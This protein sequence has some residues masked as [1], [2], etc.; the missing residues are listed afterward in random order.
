MESYLRVNLLGQGPLLIKKEL[1]DRGLT[2]VKK[3]WSIALRLQIRGYTPP[4]P[5]GVSICCLIKRIPFSSHF[6]LWPFTVSSADCRSIQDGSRNR[7]YVTRHLSPRV[8]LSARHATKNTI[9]GGNIIKR[10][11]VANSA[12]FT[13]GSALL[14]SQNSLT[15]SGKRTGSVA[16][17][18]TSTSINWGIHHVR[19]K[20]MSSAAC[21]PC[22][23]LS[24]F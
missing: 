20:V 5:R 1:Q 18:G 2:K 6:Q 22:F 10:T 11:V 16:R 21:H 14:D 7:M 3:H 9:I 13:W 8:P 17:R 15:R 4:L 19:W 12:H 24:T 23:T